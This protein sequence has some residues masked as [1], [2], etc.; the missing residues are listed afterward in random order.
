MPLNDSTVPALWLVELVMVNPA[1]SRLS[2]PGALPDTMTVAV[3]LRSSAK[4]PVEKWNV[5]G[6][7]TCDADVVVTRDEAEPPRARVGAL[8][9]WEAS[10]SAG[11]LPVSKLA[12][13]TLQAM[14]VA[15][16]R[17]VHMANH[18]LGVDA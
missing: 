15:V 18:R 4:Y 7:A 16:T 3:K 10:D 2:I 9:D 11:R 13:A 1:E 8:T 6:I 12:S 14:A 17:R 5:R